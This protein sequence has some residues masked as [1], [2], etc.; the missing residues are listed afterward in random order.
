MDRIRQ[1]LVLLLVAGIPAAMPLIPATSQDLCVTAGPVTYRLS[2]SA[3]SPDVRVRIDHAAVRPDLRLRLVDRAEIADLALVDDADRPAGHTCKVMGE[4]RTARIVTGPSD[5]TVS[6][7]RE[8]HDA[9]FALYLQSARI[10]QE[11]AAALFALMRHVQTRAA[12]LAQA[13]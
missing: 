3:E 1:S 11:D 4:I 12:V 6:I 8:P 5:V 13:R 7:S 10:S 2:P 9:D